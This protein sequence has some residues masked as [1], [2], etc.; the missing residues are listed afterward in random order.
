MLSNGSQYDDYSERVAQ[1]KSNKYEIDESKA[2]FN[3]TN[4]DNIEN[5]LENRIYVPNNG[6]SNTNNERP[7]FKPTAATQ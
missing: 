1:T 2:Y 4:L 7:K 6:N 3:D 5:F